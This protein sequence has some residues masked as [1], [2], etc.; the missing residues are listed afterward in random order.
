[1]ARPKVPPAKSASAPAGT[2]VARPR[3]QS[4]RP[5]A[6]TKATNATKPAVSPAIAVL[7]QF[8]ELFRVSQKHFQRIEASCGVSGAALWALAEIGKGGGL[9]VSD[10]AQRMSVHLSTASNLLGK[11]EA[12][13][14]VTRSR[15]AADRRAVT[16]GLAPKGR[17]LLAM[18][19]KPAEGV[20]PDALSRMSAVALRRLEADLAQLLELTSVRSLREG[21]KTLADP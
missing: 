5:D 16:L 13:E 17:R 15:C 20:I 18:A 3:S 6:L 11:L 8:R 1:M 14:L 9:T 7:R 4:R 12:R 19:P 2:R 21:L 10:L